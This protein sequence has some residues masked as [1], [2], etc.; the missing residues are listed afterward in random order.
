MI[1]EKYIKVLYVD[2]ETERIRIE[3]R[4]DLLPYLGGVGIASK[5]LQENIK[6][7]LKPTAPEQPIVFAIGAGTYIFPVLS[8]TVAMFVSPLTGELGESHARGR[9]ATSK[10]IT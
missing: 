2:L 3:H 10:M 8:K 9:R 6:P 1:N 7:D 4:E 5:L